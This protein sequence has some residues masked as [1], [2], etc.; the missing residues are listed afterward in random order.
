MEVRI[1]QFETRRGLERR[2]F[3]E[4]WHLP[5]GTV[6]RGVTIHPHICSECIGGDHVH[7]HTQQTPVSLEDRTAQLS[8]KHVET[9]S[10]LLN[11]QGRLDRRTGELHELMGN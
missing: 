10:A 4:A 5:D 11:A 1:G 3:V 7:V 9:V 2:M 6:V 8:A